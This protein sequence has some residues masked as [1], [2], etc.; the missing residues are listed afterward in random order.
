MPY[1]VK[2]GKTD[3]FDETFK[4]EG[5]AKTAKYYAI[6]GAKTNRSAFKTMDAKIVKVAKSKKK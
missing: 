6:L 5:E 2:V 4:T 1:K 3:M